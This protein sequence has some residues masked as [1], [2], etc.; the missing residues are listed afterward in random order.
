M[1]LLFVAQLSGF[2]ALLLQLQGVLMLWMIYQK[3]VCDKLTAMQARK[4]TRYLERLKKLKQRTLRRKRRE[5]WYNPGGTDDWWKRM[6]NGETLEDTWRKNF[7]LSREEFMV[8]LA[9]L[10]PYVAPDYTSPNYRAL[11]AEKK[12]AVTL[13][14]LKDTGSLSMT[15]IT[16]GLAIPTVSDI[17]FQVCKTI[18]FILGQKY[19]KLPQNIEEMQRKVAEFEGKYGMVQAFGCIDRTHIASRKPYRNSQ[20]FF[21]YK[22]YHS[23]N[24]QAGCDSKGTFMDVDCRWPGS[25]H[26]AKV[27]SHSDINTKLRGGIL[28]KTYQTLIPGFEKVPN[29]LI[30][31]PAYPLLPYCM[32]EYEISDGNDK[33]VFNNLLRSARNPIECAFGRLKARWSV[34]TKKIDLDLTTVPL[35]VFACFVLHNFCERNKTCIDEELVKS[36]M[37]VA[38]T[39][40]EKNVPDPI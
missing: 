32:K 37:Q 8:L 34:L 22:G 19:I 15:A 33:V 9:E 10:K 20:D 1:I 40:N 18:A 30:G 28:P 31:D 35:V 23:L 3:H 2:F 12:L 38:S 4:R 6:I 24:V 13:Y 27:F 36:Q 21:C 14:Y 5:R 39:V 7:R 11:S 25:V 26:D 17:L 29:F 16:F